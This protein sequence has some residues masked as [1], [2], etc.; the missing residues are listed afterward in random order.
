M[1]SSILL[2]LD[3]ELRLN[4]LASQT[5]RSKADCLREIIEHGH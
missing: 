3:V 5:K 2:A 1:A 4:F